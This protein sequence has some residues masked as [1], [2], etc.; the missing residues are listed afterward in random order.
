MLTI[1]CILF[2][3]FQLLCILIIKLWM[4]IIT[5]NFYFELVGTVVAFVFT[6][7]EGGKLK[8]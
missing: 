5:L 4:V 2:K 6:M 1:L 3:T 7:D 8:W